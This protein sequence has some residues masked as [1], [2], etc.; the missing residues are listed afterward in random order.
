MSHR[1][2]PGS[3]RQA[4]PVTC[5]KD[6]GGE[7]PLLAHV[8]DGRVVRITNNPLGGPYL[9]GCA[10]GR[11]LPDVL[12]APDR[13]KKPLVRN[14]PRGS[15]GFREVEWPEALDLVATRLAEIKSRY[16]QEAI[17]H[18][19][20][21]GAPRGALHNTNRLAK[22]FL[23]LS[24]GYTETYGNY[25]MAAADYVT[26]FVLGTRLAGIAPATLQFSNLIV[27]WGANISDTRLGTETESW[28]REARRRGIDVIVVDPRRSA[29]VRRLG[30]QWLP[31]WPGTDT[32]LMMAVLYV[33]IQEG[34]VNRPFADRVSLGFGEL[35]RYVLGHGAEPAKT[36]AWAEARCGTPAE[37]IVAFARQ[38]GLTHPAALI[39][40]LSI[41]RTVGG[42]EAIRAAIAL[43]I[44]TGNL[45]V[46]GGSSGALTWGLLPPPRMGAI[47]VPAN[48][49]GAAVPVV[50]WPDAILDPAQLPT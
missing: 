17:L 22:R 26:P 3:Q 38:Y 28:I 37:Q 20:G 4:V 14:G 35:E 48:P 21:S 49:S 39:P 2:T 44:A 40:G 32:A 25:S 24:G 11:L 12:Y 31:V 27:L 50:Q 15:G 30:T 36:P 7:C 18:L 47:G 8:R 45:G 5:N 42:E 19:G 41:Q 13:L 43:Q 46:L 23:S 34:L 16:G 1:K 10:K 29:S 9:T 6:C 33:L